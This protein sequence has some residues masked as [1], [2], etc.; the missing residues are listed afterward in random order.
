MAQQEYEIANEKSK[1]NH[2]DQIKIKF[3]YL[4]GQI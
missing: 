3:K 2:M 1:H 4:V